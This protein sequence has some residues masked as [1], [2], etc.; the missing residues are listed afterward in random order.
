MSGQ[1][2]VD[3]VDQ[4]A[5]ELLGGVEPLHRLAGDLPV[6][7]ILELDALRVGRRQLRRRGRD[8]AVARRAVRRG[9]RDD[10]VRDG[11][12]ADRHFPLVRGGLQQ[13]HARG[14]AAAPD[15]ILRHADAAAAAGAHSPHTRLAREVPA[16]RGELGRDLLPVALELLGDE[17]RESGQR[18]LPHL[19]TRDADHA[20]V[21]GP[22]HDPG[23]DLGAVAGALRQR[24]ADERQIAGRAPGRRRRPRGA[25]DEFAAGELRGLAQIVLSWRLLTIAL[26]ALGGALIARAVPFAA[27]CTAAR[28]R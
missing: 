12:F 16:G 24:D 15:V 20:G 9:M 7:R 13:H 3:R 27:M 4:A 5:V 19:R 22:D 2:D 23:V 6:V 18:S 21:V 26:R 28:I 14:R 25:D 11:H 8:L 1:L 10:A 17:L